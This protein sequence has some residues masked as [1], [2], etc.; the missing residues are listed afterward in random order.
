MSEQ[1]A[2]SRMIRAYLRHG[3]RR[4]RVLPSREMRV[5]RYVRPPAPEGDP[6]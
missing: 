1:R 5:K 4:F 3:L 6:S 2:E